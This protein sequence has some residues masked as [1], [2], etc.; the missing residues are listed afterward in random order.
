MTGFLEQ[1][2]RKALGDPARVRELA[3]VPRPAWDTMA[4]ALQVPGSVDADGN[5]G[6]LRDLTLVEQARIESTRR[7]ALLRMGIPPDSVGTPGPSTPAPVAGPGAPA[8][9]GQPGAGSRRLKLSAVLDPT[10]DADVVSLGNLEIQKLYADYKAKFGDHPSAEAD[11]SADQL[12]SLKQVVAA[13]SVPYADFSLFG[14]HGLRLLRKQ[15]FTSYTLNVATGEW[16]KKEQPGPSSYHS[17]V[18]AWKVYRTALLLL[19]TVDAERL[20]AYAEHVRSFVTQFGDSAWWL[21]YRAEN[22]LRCEHMERLRRTLHDKP[23]YG[24]TAARPWNAVYAAAIRNGDYWTRELVT[25]AT[26]WLSQRPGRPASP[27]RGGGGQPSSGRRVDDG[28]DAVNPSPKK[29]SKKKRYEGE[30]QSV[31]QDG[32][33]VKN[34]R[35]TKICPDFN[36]GKCGSRKPQSKCK[37]GCSHQCNLCLGPHSAVDCTRS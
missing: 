24:Y 37:D 5:P 27:N 4:A 3:L 18:E 31:K 10:L 36:K 16:S 28:A 29:K 12:A 14:P 33:F 26:L 13:G 30:D 1:S 22:R 25:P 20:D 21:V 23:A 35:G 32:V 8:T 15:T 11:P 6:P 9:G 19:E 7:V 2:L 34:R 17:W